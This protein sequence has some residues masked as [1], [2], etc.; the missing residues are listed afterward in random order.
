MGQ[1]VMFG[2]QYRLQLV[3]NGSYFAT[4]NE[5]ALVRSPTA[6]K[7]GTLIQSN[8]AS[9]EKLWRYE[10]WVFIILIFFVF[11]NNQQVC[12]LPRRKSL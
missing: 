9:T 8:C 7:L 3:T 6:P 1:V 5:Q 2:S 12:P 11:C 10:K 4:S